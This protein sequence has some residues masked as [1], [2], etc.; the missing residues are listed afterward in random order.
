AQECFERALRVH[1]DRFA[2]RDVALASE[3]AGNANLARCSTLVARM[4]DITA[5]AA[6][7]WLAFGRTLSGIADLYLATERPELAQ[8]LLDEVLLINAESY[9]AGHWRI[10]VAQSR[11][12]PCL[13]M[14]GKRDEAN[15]VA[16]STL[17]ALTTALGE[18]HFQVRAAEERIASLTVL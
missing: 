13:A 15:E 12:A 14:Q 10:A 3:L 6:F 17:R 1:S 4:K 8:P 2:S 16:Q 5:N 7:D 9:P 18:A 11:L